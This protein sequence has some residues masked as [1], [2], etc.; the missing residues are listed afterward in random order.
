METENVNP[1][2]AGLLG[3]KIRGGTCDGH[4]SDVFSD[5]IMFVNNP[6]FVTGKRHYV[7]GAALIFKPIDREGRRRFWRSAAN[8]EEEERCYWYARLFGYSKNEYK[9]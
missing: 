8:I 6:A 9:G 5:G 1:V 3:A 4:L 7:D 2:Q